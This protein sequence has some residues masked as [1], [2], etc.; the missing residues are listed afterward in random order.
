VKRR[1]NSFGSLS[2]IGSSKHA[3]HSDDDSSNKTPNKESIA[4]D[5]GLKDKINASE[6]GQSQETFEFYVDSD[7]DDVSIGD[8]SHKSEVSLHTSFAKHVCCPFLH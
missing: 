4:D 7:A 8:L 5:K 2:D 3:D 6:V 1:F